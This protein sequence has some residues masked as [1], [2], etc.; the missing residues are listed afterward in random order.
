MRARPS[1]IFAILA[2]AGGALAFV[3][4][5]C[6]DTSRAQTGLGTDEPIRVLGGQ[7][8]GGKLPA[9]GKGPEVH[10]VESKNN[11]VVQG[12]HQHV[13]GGGV[14]K[15]AAALA[16]RFAD[17]G[18]GYWI[19]PTGTFDPTSGDITYSFPY[20]IAVDAPV[21]VH[22]L[23]LSAV[24]LDGNFGPASELSLT[25]KSRV[26]SGKVVISLEW[27]SAAD[28]DLQLRTPEGKIV[29]GKHPTT[30]VPVDGGIDFDAPEGFGELDRDSN[31]ACLVD[32]YDEESVVWNTPPTPGRYAIW[33]NLFDACKTPGASFTVT[34]RRD[35]E[36]LERDSG[37][38]LAID[39]NGRAG[40][41]QDGNPPGL[42]ITEVSF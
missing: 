32:G 3:S 24:D 21:G 27:D 7:Y 10:T 11:V 5:G 42:F 35:G 40:A 12:A 15:T 33:V 37:R 19:V 6:G 18:H 22:P 38:V 34:V 28:L 25:I 2:I 30:L 20:D 41:D 8:V 9:P 26:P 36:V 16:I 29:D 17:I 1:A 4:G 39:A 14:G 23:L 31:H 13:L